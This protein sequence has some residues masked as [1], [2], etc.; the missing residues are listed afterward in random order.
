MGNNIDP[1][2]RQSPARP[3]IGI[4]DEEEEEDED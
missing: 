4:T 2:A 1:S 3:Y